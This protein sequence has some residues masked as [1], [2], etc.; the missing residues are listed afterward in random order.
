MSVIFYEADELA[1]LAALT[2][3]NLASDQGQRDLA[4]IVEDLA[5]YS[6]ANA[7]AFRA[8]Y[9][10]D[11][12][13]GIDAAEIAAAVRPIHKAEQVRSAECVLAG[14]RYNLI[15]NSGEDF[16]TIRALGLILECTQRTYRKPPLDAIQEFDHG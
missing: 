15:A 2:V 12:A 10:A 1:A 11:P 5:E 4:R 6:R 8:T 16:A 7:A 14:M 9:P 3:G 13:Q